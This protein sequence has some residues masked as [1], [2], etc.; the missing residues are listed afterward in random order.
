MTQESLIQGLIAEARTYLG[1]PW[2]HQGR[3][4]NGVDC[5]GFLILSFLHMR[6]HIDEIRGY[7]RKPNGKQ[8]KDIMDSQPN[9]TC[10]NPPYSPGD[11]V[12][13]RIRKDPQHVALLTGT[14]DKL[15][16]IHSYNGGDRKVVEHNFADYWRKKIVAVYRLNS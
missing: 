9:L 11:V 13:F 5:V 14:K 1:V 15:Y 6:V 2:K 4:K 16:M 3:T 12:L 7:G 10:V 8:L